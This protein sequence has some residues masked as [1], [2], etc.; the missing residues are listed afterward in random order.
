MEA[1]GDEV[2]KGGEAGEGGRGR[3]DGEGTLGMRNNDGW[4]KAN[5]VTEEGMVKKGRKKRTD[6]TEIQTLTKTEV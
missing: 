1:C 4:T 3:R 5:E 2:R 6:K